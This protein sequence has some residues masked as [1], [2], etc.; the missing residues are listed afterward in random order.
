MPPDEEGE[1]YVDRHTSKIYYWPLASAETGGVVA[2]REQL[3]VSQ[4]P[5]ILHIEGESGDGGANTNKAKEISFS[6]ITFA[7]T[8]TTFLREKYRYRA[9]SYPLIH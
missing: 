7:H 3:V 5:T 1:F 6:G 4:L 2:A 9:P 8:Q